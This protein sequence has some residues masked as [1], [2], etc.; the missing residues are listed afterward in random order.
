MTTLI[1]LL[2]LFCALRIC[3]LEKTENTRIQLYMYAVGLGLTLSFFIYTD[4][5]NI[6]DARNAARIERKSQADQSLRRS[7]GDAVK[8]VGIIEN[9]TDKPANEIIDHLRNET[10]YF[11]NRLSNQIDGTI[12]LLSKDIPQE[13]IKKMQE[14][15]DLLKK[16]E[17]GIVACGK[18]ADSAQAGARLAAYQSAVKVN[19]ELLARRLFNANG[20][21]TLDVL[22]ILIRDSEGNLNMYSEINSPRYSGLDVSDE[23]MK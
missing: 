19:A 15:N 23:E 4:V 21:D 2:T 22:N 17:E 13:N 3:K 1:C 6:I 20:D 8:I 5:T 11:V 7:L 16:A 12:Y 14:K 9:S 18:Q 10:P